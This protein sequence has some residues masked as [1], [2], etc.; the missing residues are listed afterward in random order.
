MEKDENMMRRCVEYSIQASGRK[1]LAPQIVDKDLIFLKE[2][3]V[4][5]AYL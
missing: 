2:N 3:Q 4:F 5:V 1:D